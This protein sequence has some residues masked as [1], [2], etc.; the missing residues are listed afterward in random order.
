MPIAGIAAMRS[1]VVIAA[2]TVDGEYHVSLKVTDAAGRN[3]E[4]T[5]LL[6]YGSQ[7]SLTTYEDIL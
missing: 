3:D 7:R 6:N 5:A 2:P 4:S 1:R